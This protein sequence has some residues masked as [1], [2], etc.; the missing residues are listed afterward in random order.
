MSKDNANVSFAISLSLK[1][2]I[3]LYITYIYT[4]CICFCMNL[5]MTL[6]ITRSLYYVT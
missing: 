1:R 5:M 6:L 4:N 2:F 3:S